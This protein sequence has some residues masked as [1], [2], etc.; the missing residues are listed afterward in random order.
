M[1][2]A[3]VLGDAEIE[4]LRYLSSLKRM[5]PAVLSAAAQAVVDG[6]RD[7]WAR[8]AEAKRQAERSIEA[9]LAKCESPPERALLSAIVGMGRG[10]GCDGFIQLTGLDGSSCRAI[11]QFVLT[12]VRHRIDIALFGEGVQVAV[13]VDGWQFHSATPALAASTNRRQRTLLGAGWIVVPFSAIEV[14]DSADSC[15]SEVLSLLKGMPF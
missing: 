3:N 1:S 15:A 11:P 12:D 7:D 5:E 14:N 6:W 10:V 9:F 13:E 2:A 8:E 4:A